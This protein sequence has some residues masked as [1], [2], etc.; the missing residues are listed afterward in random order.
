MAVAW[1]LQCVV[2]AFTVQCYL[3]IFLQKLSSPTPMFRMIGHYVWA[4][5]VQERFTLE[6]FT[7]QIN[8]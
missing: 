7:W 4:L 8:K 1:G 6:C 3:G 5:S 2:Q